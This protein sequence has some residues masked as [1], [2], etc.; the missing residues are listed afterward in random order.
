MQIR[1]DVAHMIRIITGEGKEI[2]SAEIN[3]GE[4]KDG[5]FQ[6]GTDHTTADRITFFMD[7]E[8]NGDWEAVDFLKSSARQ[9]Q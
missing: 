6:T 2:I 9:R 5:R 8:N 1:Y 4:Y 7:W 3:I